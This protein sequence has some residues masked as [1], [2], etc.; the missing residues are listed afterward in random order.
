MTGEECFMVKTRSADTA[1][2]ERLVMA[3]NDIE[4][5]DG[6]RTIIAFRAMRESLRVELGGEGAA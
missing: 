2:L 3:I 5:V 1:G 4:T 6:T